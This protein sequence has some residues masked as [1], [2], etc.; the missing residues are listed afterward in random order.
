MPEGCAIAV[1]H[2]PASEPHADIFFLAPGGAKIPRQWRRSA[3][4]MVLASGEMDVAY[5]GRSPVR[6]A[7]GTDA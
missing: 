5:G 3:E 6:L 2:G 4:R 1:L 7:P